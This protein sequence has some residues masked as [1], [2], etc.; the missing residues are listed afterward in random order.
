MLSRI[1]EISKHAASEEMV[2]H[3]MELLIPGAS[4]ENVTFNVT[5]AASHCQSPGLFTNYLNEL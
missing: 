4:F 2:K 3:N 5:W 1:P